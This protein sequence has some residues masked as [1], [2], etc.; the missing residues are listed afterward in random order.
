MSQSRLNR[1]ATERPARWWW[2]WAALVGVLA[3]CIFGVGLDEPRFADESAYI[4]QSYFADLFFGGRWNDLAW[5]TYPAFDLPPLPKYLIGLALRVSGQPRPGPESARQW[6]ND[7]SRVVGTPAMLWAARWPS[8]VLGALGCVA[9]YALG[10]LSAGRRA[11]VL[12]ALLL[13][14]NPL[15]RLHARRAMSDVPTEAFLVTALAVGL[16]AWQRTLARGPKPL[17]WFMMLGSG[18]LAG[19]AVLCK[20]NGA[21][22]LFVLVAWTALGLALARVEVK[23]K[24]AL[25]V[26]LG[27]AGS[28]A[29]G[30]FV[31]LNPYMTARPVH[32]QAPFKSIA[33][34]GIWGRSRWLVENRMQ[35][36]ADQKNIFPHNALR[37]PLDKAE[38][39][40][41]QGFGRFGPLGP[42]TTNSRIRFDWNQDRGGLI[43]MPWVAIGLAWAARR[44]R[45]QVRDG[46]PP[47]AWAI[48]VYF[49][50]AL[51]TITAFIPLAWDRYYLSLQAGSVLLAAG[52]ASAGFDRLSGRVPRRAEA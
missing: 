27:L 24:V 37:S 8:V 28:V 5:I 39:V 19:L 12:A 35:V 4:S 23:R 11:G 21:L 33:E 42:Y 40:L 36:S 45:D 49:L 30:T 25:G 14:A 16:W 46:E 50:V 43:W 2:A 22:A 31:A 41:V 38:A 13:M 17:A 3:A 15:Y 48:A 51:A 29:F 44:G 6:Y 18:V 10:T 7:I 20:F 9:V 32:A 47:A 52:A 34:Q 26:M 1:W